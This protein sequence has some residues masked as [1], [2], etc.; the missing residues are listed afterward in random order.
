MPVLF[1]VIPVYD[2]PHTLALCVANVMAVQLP[3][4]WSLKVIVVD[5]GVATGATMRAGLQALRAMGAGT[6]VA[7]APVGARPRCARR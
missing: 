5:D 3:A 4:Q 1:A 6:I 7:A 2:E